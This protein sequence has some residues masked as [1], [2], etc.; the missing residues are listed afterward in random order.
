MLVVQIPRT[1]S[2]SV[3]QLLSVDP[4][5]I[6]SDVSTVMT[7]KITVKIVG[8]ALS[9]FNSN[10]GLTEESFPPVFA[11]PYNPFHKSCL[12]LQKYFLDEKN[13]R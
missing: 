11:G 2:W 12:F 3:W 4:K 7:V 10:T 13:A 8:S 1:Q 5:K 9:I 6:A